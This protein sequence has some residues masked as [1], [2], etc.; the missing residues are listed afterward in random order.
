MRILTDDSTVDDVISAAIEAHALEDGGR[1]AGLLHRSYPAPPSASL[2]S[3][4]TRRIDAWLLEDRDHGRDRPGHAAVAI[5]DDRISGSAP[6]GYA[7]IERYAVTLR[8]SRDL[9]TAVEAIIHGCIPR[10][11]DFAV[12]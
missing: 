1:Q 11:T 3:G 7:A 2:P 8:S 6:D 5:I 9:D 4:A 12:L 10:R